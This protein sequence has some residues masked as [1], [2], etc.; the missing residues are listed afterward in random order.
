MRQPRDVLAVERV[1]HEKGAGPQAVRRAPRRRKAPRQHHRSVLRHLQLPER[2]GRD[3]P[4]GARHRRRSEHGVSAGQPLGRRLATGRGRRQHLHVPRVRSHAVRSTR[5]A[6]PASAHRPAQHDQVLAQARRDA[7]SGPRAVHRAREAHHDQADLGPV[8]LGH[9][10]L[11][12]HRQLRCGGQRHLHARDPALPRRRDGPA[13]QL[14]DFALA[15]RQDRQ[16]RSAPPR[17]REDAAGHVRQLQRTHLP[18]RVRWRVDDESQL[19]PGVVPAAHHQAPHRHAVHGLLGGD[20][21][22]P[23]V[24]QRPV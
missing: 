9:A 20:L 2:S 21:H 15:R 7:G 12:W 11:L 23:G 8:A 18:R 19:H 24:L 16:R 4:T 14:R 3:S 6:L 17:D 10:R 5:P 22:H 1:R 13:V